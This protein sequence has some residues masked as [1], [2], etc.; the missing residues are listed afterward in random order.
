MK[1]S[2]KKSKGNTRKRRPGPIVT[3]ITPH[4]GVRMSEEFQD[5]I[6][7]WAKRQ[8]HCPSLAAAVRRLVEIGLAHGKMP[9]SAK[10][11]RPVAY[12]IAE[13]SHFGAI[14]K[15]GVEIVTTTDRQPLMLDPSPDLAND[16]LLEHVNLPVRVGNSLTSGGLRTVGEVR[17]TSASDLLTFQNVGLRTVAVIRELSGPQSA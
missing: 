4:V 1:S 10:G 7:A 9:P 13:D 12:A 5:Q 17:E 15:S 6:R 2:M 14:S 16:T 3:G 8:S 11:T